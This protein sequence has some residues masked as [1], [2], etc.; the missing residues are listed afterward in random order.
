MASMPR[1]IAGG[2]VALLVALAGGCGKERVVDLGGGVKMSLVLIPAGSFTM[3]STD[4]QTKA[5][6]AKWPEART[7]WFS[8][9][10]PAHKVTISRAFSMGR[11]EV[12]AGQFRRFVEATN[13]KTEM[14]RRARSP[15]AQ[16][17]SPRGKSRWPRMRDREEDLSRLD[18]VQLGRRVP[19]DGAGRLLQGECLGP[20]RHARECFVVRPSGGL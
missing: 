10:K 19:L 15:K 18:R 13:H 12:T 16:S 2:L 3:G 8:D 6:L 14:P 20:S 11:H 7:E 9:E 1:G 4:E 5:L 17:S